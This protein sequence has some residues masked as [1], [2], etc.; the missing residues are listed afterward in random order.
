MG[1]MAKKKK[2]ME[3][4]EIKKASND[5]NDLEKEAAEKKGDLLNQAREKLNEQLD[6]VKH[7][8]QMVAYARCVTVR[9]KQLDEKKLIRGCKVEEQKRLDMMYEV[10]RLTEVK[11]VDDQDF[12]RKKLQKNGHGIIVDQMKERQLKRLKEKE[13]LAKE[14]QQ[15][16]KHIKELEID[17][18]QQVLN[19]KHQQKVLLDDILE[20]NQKAVEKKHDNHAKERE[21]DDKIMD[22]L[23]EKATKEAEFAEETKR[24]KDE[25]EREV[26]RLRELQGKAADRQSEI[27]A[28]RAKRAMENAERK[29]RTKEKMMPPIEMNSIR[30]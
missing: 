12:R 7:M 22:Y 25:K 20:A 8:N 6:E 3:L 14:A 16:L 15:M 5:L 17:D 24:L 30:S 18:K 23:V 11:R 26:A 28:L 27:D 10:G 13:G 21:D 2:M 9:D 4:E 1:A 19:R 29:A